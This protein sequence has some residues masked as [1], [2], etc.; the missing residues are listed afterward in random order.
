[1]LKLFQNQNSRSS[2]KQ[3]ESS[4]PFDA[5]EDAPF[6]GLA[7]HLGVP[8]WSNDKMLKKQEKVKVVS[9]I[10]LIKLIGSK[11]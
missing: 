7:L 6:I 10:E 2:Y 1:M 5:K 3:A 8:L 11:E 4:L 9:T